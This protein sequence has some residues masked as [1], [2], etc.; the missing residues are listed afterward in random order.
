MNS[1]SSQ[2]G[3]SIPR[4]CSCC[5]Y[6][7]YWRIER[8]KYMFFDTLDI[9][10]Y[11]WCFIVGGIICVIAQVLI[12][13]TK[14]TPA[15]ILVLFVTVGAVLRWVRD[16]W[17]HYKLCWSRSN[18]TI[19]RIWSKLSKRSNQRCKRIWIIGC[20]YRRNK[21]SS[22]RNCSSNLFRIYSIISCKT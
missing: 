2:Q 1:T 12:D 10:D 9:M 18:S 15:R 16:L 8:R 20:V 7:K 21:S 5:L 22:R 6:W 11:V 14:I 17:T 13:K 19:N 3:E 4:N